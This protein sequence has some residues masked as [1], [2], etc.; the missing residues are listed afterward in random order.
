[1]S[2]S[3]IP[4]QVNAQKVVNKNF[5]YYHQICRT[6]TCQGAVFVGDDGT[7]FNR[8]ISGEMYAFE[9]DGT[10]KWTYELPL[11]YLGYLDPQ[12]KPIVDTERNITYVSYQTS[13]RSSKPGGVVALDNHGKSKWHFKLPAGHPMEM[14]LGDDGSI[15]F[16]S[17]DP[18]SSSTPTFYSLNNDGTLRWSY[19]TENQLL[20]KTLIGSDG[21]IYAADKTNV[22]AFNP[23]G[24]LKWKHE[25]NDGWTITSLGGSKRIKGVYISTENEEYKALRYISGGE[26]L[27]GTLINSRPDDIEVAS[28]GKVYL[29]GE[30][31]E[32]YN[33]EGQLWESMPLS[34]V[35]SASVTME[36]EI[37]YYLGVDDNPRIF[38]ASGIN[39]TNGEVI[40]NKTFHS[41]Y[42]MGYGGMDAAEN[43]MYVNTNEG[44][45]YKIWEGEESPT[46]IIMPNVDL[47]TNHSHPIARLNIR[48]EGVPLLK[49]QSDGSYK[50]YRTLE[51][52]HFYRTY[53][54]DGAY[55][56]VGGP[57]Y[58]KN[59]EDKMSAHI[60][61]ILVNDEGVELYGPDGQIHRMLKKGE[62]IRVYNYK[63]Y[64]Y[65][66]G[67][68]YY[69]NAQYQ[70][71]F[72]V[73]F[74]QTKEDVQMYQPGGEYYKT[75]PAGQQYRVYGIDGNRIM[76]GGGYYIM[77]DPSKITYSKN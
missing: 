44:S 61:R 57:Y 21:T 65:N 67:G 54:A 35:T 42:Y 33:E 20:K 32:A 48:R 49:K 62:A 43:T 72:Y 17:N 11:D 75:L 59:E 10:K 23:K 45:I 29:L 26:E 66:V 64:Y 37:I 4:Q 12:Y 13:I 1:M 28:D 3:V 2:L 8:Y 74:V 71:K 70:T 51:T 25:T 39:P 34:D 63:P 41:L 40:W 6:T 36:D 27:L 69:V 7:I 55:Y 31:I 15:Y 46:R 60:G 56:N 77:D 73:G 5:F 50:Y 30:K 14:A 9:K 19:E 24:E 58:V 68:G 47:P 76:V 22:Y 38:H 16:S 18:K 52:G 53:G